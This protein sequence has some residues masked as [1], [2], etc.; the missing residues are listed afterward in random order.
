MDSARPA[1]RPGALLALALA[2]TT[3]LSVAFPVSTS[4]APADP[5]LRDVV[6]TS[7]TASA[8][9]LADAVHAAGGTVRNALPLAGGVH[10]A[11]PAGAV[12]PPAFSVVENAPLTLASRP[13]ASS[14]REGSAVRETLGVG[15]AGTQG[16]G[17]RIA[18]LD[19]GVAESPDL[20]GRLTHHDV[21]G[22]WQAGEA[23]DPYGHGTFVAGAAAGNGTASDGRYAG[24]A[25]G[26]HVLD[27]RVADEAGTTDLSTVLLGL[28]KAAELEADIVNLSLSS[29]SP[30]PHQ[31]DPL[32]VALD[33]LWAR[34]VVV[35]VPSGNDGPGRG[36]VT[37][38]GSDPTLLTVG[39][40]DEH[41]TADRRDDTV[42]AFS[43]RGPTLQG[44]G[45]P[46]LVAPGRS[47]VSL[48]APGSTV[49]VANPESVVAGAYLRGSGT[50]FATAVVA[51]AAAVLLE[52]RPDLSP[53][54]VKALVLGT[55]YTAKGLK[56][57]RAAG[58]GGL[59]VAAA[60]QAPAPEVAPVEVDLPPAGD[61]AQ[62]HALLQAL[63][64]GDRAAA[65]QAWSRLSP[66][67]HRWAGHR[68][69]GIDPVGHRWAKDAWS[70]HRWAGA[71]GSADEWQQRFWAADVWAATQW[72][73]D[74]FVGH[75]WAGHR[76]GGH[77]WGGH[78]WGAQNWAGH[79]WAGHRWAALWG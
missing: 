10:A 60:L 8:T 24:A 2:A 47:L 36:S 12:L 43:G 71:D 52:E 76:W 75:R 64:D 11:L 62:W 40:L 21:S 38:P 22:T 28:E 74:S 63:M 35:V 30:L 5:S 19:T 34:G 42:P 54:Q 6:V 3:A 44:H 1:R 7:A 55:A 39:A 26:A 66:E 4:G 46:D 53:D 59:D 14:A 27:V 73:S 72:A 67:G 15:P 33:R 23:H 32:T 78:R 18:V 68:W 69:A 13:I 20:E 16:A 41:L 31:V 37:S 65:A 56:D 45:K 58:A 77:R 79:R 57:S 50:S 29:G 49:D 48:R 17:V 9:A 51:G 61:L 70:G 25:P